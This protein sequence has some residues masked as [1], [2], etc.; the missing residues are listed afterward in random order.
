M[1][2]CDKH[3]GSERIPRL[4][5]P[6]DGANHK[7]LLGIIPNT[8][9]RAIPYRVLTQVELREIRW[10]SWILFYFNFLTLPCSYPC[11]DSQ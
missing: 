3:L 10:T 2:E 4:C 11:I 5:T 7:G 8:I 9:F 6:V 1:K